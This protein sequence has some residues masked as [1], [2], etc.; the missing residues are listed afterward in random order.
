M[1]G[2]RGGESLGD[3]GTMDEHGRYFEYAEVEQREM[4]AFNEGVMHG[5]A[6]N[7][8]ESASE[9]GSNSTENAQA[10]DAGVEIIEISDSDSFQSFDSNSHWSPGQSTDGGAVASLNDG[11]DQ[12]GDE[13]AGLGPLGP[14]FGNYWEEDEPL[15]SMWFAMPGRQASL[16]DEDGETWECAEASAQVFERLD[17]TP[18]LLLAQS[19]GE[20]WRGS[21]IIFFSDVGPRILR[22]SR[23]N[24]PVETPEPEALA[25]MY[26]DVAD[27]GDWAAELAEKEYVAHRTPIKLFY[28]PFNVPI[29]PCFIMASY[30]YRDY[31]W[32]GNGYNVP[33]GRLL[34]RS[35]DYVGPEYPICI[36]CQVKKME[37]AEQQVAE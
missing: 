24:I 8:R 32:N 6:L 16:F 30:H 36:T 20:D 27:M 10:D 1:C 11:D 3:S 19:W 15:F 17:G 25:E 31:E 5:Q 22:L 12:L 9:N 37:A 18:I 21:L 23:K 2:L 13:M 7:I 34:F 35:M 14:W 28:H 33:N 26:N 4:V 29:Q